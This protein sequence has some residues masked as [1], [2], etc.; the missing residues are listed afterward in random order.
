[1]LKILP[2]TGMWL[3][4]ASTLT[5]QCQKV[6]NIGPT[7]VALSQKY[8]DCYLR[9]FPLDFHC[10]KDLLVVLQLQQ[11]K[12]LVIYPFEKGYGSKHFVPAV[13]CFPQENN[14]QALHNSNSRYSLKFYF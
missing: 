12:T 8:K 3:K 5:K 4:M 2:H 11:A 6:R 9:T 13:P 14:E 1:M 7:V 10:M